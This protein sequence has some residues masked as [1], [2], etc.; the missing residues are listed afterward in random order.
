MVEEINKTIWLLWFQGWDNA[1]LLVKQA[2]KSWELHNNNWNIIYL[3]NNNLK[4]YLGNE[5]DFL[6]ER[7][8][9]LLATKADYI[10]LLLLHKYGG[11]WAD[12]NVFCLQPLDNWIHM[13]LDNIGV[14][15][16]HGYSLRV[17]I[18]QGCAVWFIAAYKGN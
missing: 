18:S 8:D 4:T 9:I 11:V 17:G 14:W 2:R 3:D 16:Y 6:L 10:R 5:A 1:P 12:A 7:D 15:M 13:I